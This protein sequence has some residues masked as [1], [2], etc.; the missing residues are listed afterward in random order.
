MNDNFHRYYLI[1]LESI[2]A[3]ENHEKS[4]HLYVNGLKT[5]E[6]KI[7][8]LKKYSLGQSRTILEQETPNIQNMIM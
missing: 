8:N 4:S 6:T 3:I 2:T 7:Y 1:G 5:A